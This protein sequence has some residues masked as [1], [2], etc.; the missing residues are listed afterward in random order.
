MVSDEL[1]GSLAGA[2]PEIFTGPVLH[3]SKCTGHVTSSIPELFDQVGSE[4]QSYI[5]D[6]LV[7]HLRSRVKACFLKL[8]VD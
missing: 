3:D 7:N 1:Q 8:G 5:I 4:I 6:K 2:S